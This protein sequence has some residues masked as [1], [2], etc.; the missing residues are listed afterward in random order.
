MIASGAL[1]L[2]A[3]EPVTDTSE[4]VDLAPTER[5]SSYLELVSTGV[6]ERIESDGAAS[7]AF[8]PDSNT[9]WAGL[10]ATAASEGGIDLYDVDGES[11]FRMTGPRLWGLASA[12][13]FQLRG[14]NLPLLFGADRDTN[15][16]RAY[17]LLRSGPE[18]IEAPVEP[19]GPS[20]DIAAV[21]GLGEGIGYVDLMVLSRGTTGEIWRISDTGGDLI[22][23]TRR[24]RFDLPSPARTC[25]SGNGFI[26]A[27][28]PAGGIY[29]LADDGTVE[30][31]VDGLAISLAAGEFLG[32]PVLILTDG[33]SETV[34]V[35]DGRTL[36]LIGD[37]I[38]RNGFSIPGVDEPGALAVS[39]ASFG[40]AAYQSGLVAVADQDDG[41]VRLIAR[42]T[43]ARG[44]TV[45]D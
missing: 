34:E 42:E 38:I 37:V 9:A 3:C 6:M 41:R 32:R 8:L 19:I 40:G 33:T 36:A 20:G 21:C 23:A 2:A 35:R 18:L 28:G 43:F 12:P 17:A 16:V 24:A 26:Y 25:T 1:A 7:V 22:G 29:R 30:G 44:I 39:D 5:D 15:L 27:A 31:Q 4:F 14:E 13:G 10:I 11:V 45:V